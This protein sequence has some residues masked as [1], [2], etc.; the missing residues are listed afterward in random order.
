MSVCLKIAALFS[1][2]LALLLTGCGRDNGASYGPETDDAG[3]REGQQLEKQDRIQEA[4]VAYLKVIERRGQQ[5]SAESHLSAGLILK[6]HVRDSLEAIHHFRKYLEQQPNSPK[7]A[8]VKGQ[9]EDAKREFAKTLAASPLDSQAARLDG[10][11]QIERQQREIDLLKAELT[12]ARGGI[13]ALRPMNTLRVPVV[14]APELKSSTVMITIPTDEP[15]PIALAPMDSRATEP[16]ASNPR[17][18]A[19]DPSATKPAATPAGRPLSKPTAPSGAG[20]R[21]HKV[22]QSDT[23]FGIAKKYYGTATATKVQEILKANSDILS[24]AAALKPGM[25]LRIP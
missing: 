18:A 17:T 11:D 25:E 3:Y 1:L 24:S 6:Q 9:I 15:S 19:T 5:D 14:E 21:R 23:L 13:G 4:L 16:P 10:A 20:M 2:G 12:A 8:L 22:I 7:A